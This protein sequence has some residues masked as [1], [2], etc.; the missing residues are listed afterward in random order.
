[1][2]NVGDQ[3]IEQAPWA[4]SVMAGGGTALVPQPEMYAD[5]L[6]NRQL[7]LWPYTD[8]ADS[9]VHWGNEIITV[10]QRA[11]TEPF[12]FGMN[13]TKKWAAYYN[14]GVLFQ[15]SFDYRE[16]AVYPDYGCSFELYTN[17]DFLEL[18][19]LGPLVMIEPGETI[20]HEESWIIRR[21]DSIVDSMKQLPF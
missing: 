13:Q 1:V 11:G 6:P 19:S 18:E 4:L 8:M 7:I 10:A 17:E 15:K 12:K 20:A 3:A 16:D 14:D 21:S 2:T 9:R 5:L